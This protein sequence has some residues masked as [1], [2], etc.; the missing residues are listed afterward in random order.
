MKQQ[1]MR[2]PLPFGF[3]YPGEP[4]ESNP[5]IL[6]LAKAQRGETLATTGNGMLRRAL[7]RRFKELRQVRVKEGRQHDLIDYLIKEWQR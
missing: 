3:Q 7:V 6:A 5:I 2:V 4:A 1:L